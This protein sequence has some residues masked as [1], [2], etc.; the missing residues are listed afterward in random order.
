LA[1][2][3]NKLVGAISTAK[4]AEGEEQ[5][6][7]ASHW[8]LVWWRFR[9]HQLAMGAAVVIAL[10]YVISIG[11]EFMATQAPRESISKMSYA[12]PQSLNLEFSDAKLRPFVYGIDS[13]RDPETYAMAH[14]IDQTQKYYITYFARNPAY[15]YKFWG[16]FC[17]DRHLMVAVVPEVEMPAKADCTVD[18][19]LVNTP[20]NI[21]VLGTDRMGR[22]MWSRIMLGTRISMS[23]GLVG[24]AVS[25][26]IGIFMGG[27]SGLRGGWTDLVIQRLIEQLRAMPTIPLWLALA[28]AV[29]ADW[30]ITKQY[31]AIVVILSVIGWTTLAREVR[32]RFLAMREE[33]FVLAARLYGS[34]Q[35]RIIFRHMLPSFVSHV[36]ASISLSIPGIILAETSLSFLGLGM[37]PP[38]I[39]WGVL[40][41]EAQNVRTVDQAPWLLL[42]GVFVVIA[43]LAFN[44]L[45]DGLRDAADPYSNRNS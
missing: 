2:D 27:I 9:R 28:A 43:V 44:F 41:K 40:L 16:L 15:A 38:A 20:R 19:V 4:N 25:L 11:S 3:E 37:R 36:I 10:F 14:S 21:Y 32:G 17:T 33:D 13:V 24:V 5:Q 18:N 7:I 39:S 12:P 6:W 35:I 31:F 29:P 22:D 8:T 42:P 30:S 34:G 1:T 23:I 26:I 45:G